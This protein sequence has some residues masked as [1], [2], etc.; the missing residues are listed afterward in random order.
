MKKYLTFGFFF[1][2]ILLDLV[3]VSSSFA[4]SFKEQGTMQEI[5]KFNSAS[6]D[7][8][9]VSL[10]DSSLT[11]I[12]QDSLLD[13]LLIYNVS[14]FDTEL[15]DTAASRFFL[16]YEEMKDGVYNLN[17]ADILEIL[18][19]DQVIGGSHSFL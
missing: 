4:V 15:E 17:L 1:K 3:L 10:L 6:G 8:S 19:L 5:L 7:S 9:E 2:S 11:Y 18:C 13:F 16:I 12:N 14:Y